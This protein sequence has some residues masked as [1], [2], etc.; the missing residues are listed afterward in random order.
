DNFDSPQSPFF[1][2]TVAMEQEG[3]WKANYVERN[4]PTMGN[5]RGLSREQLKSLTR[6]GRRENCEW[7]AAPFPSARADKPPA[8]FAAMDILVIP[9]TSHHKSEAFE[10]IAFVNRQDIME[11]LVSMHCKNSPLAKMSDHYIQNH[12]NPYIEV[13]EE[14]A[15]SPNA[16]PVPPIPVWPEVRTELDVAIERIC[17]DEATPLQALSDAQ[18]RA[19]AAVDRFFARQD[20]RARR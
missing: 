11:K 2:G 19:Q 6:Q 7:A 9:S 5:R 20:M 16:R 4:N 13:F 12:P 1:A 14:L 8:T 3:P 17:L 15:A 18:N 10:F